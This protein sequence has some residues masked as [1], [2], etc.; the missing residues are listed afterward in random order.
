VSAQFVNKMEKEAGPSTSQ[1]TKYVSNRDIATVEETMK[2]AKK[3]QK[4]TKCLL[5]NFDL[6]LVINTDQTSCQYQTTYNR[7]LDFQGVKTVFVKK[8]NINKITHSYTAQ[9]SIT[10]SGKLLP[11]VY[12][13]LQKLKN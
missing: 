11:Q 7:S 5:S 9:Y 3:F 1:I 12:K 10:A 6:D 4:Q 13:N 2:T 8:H